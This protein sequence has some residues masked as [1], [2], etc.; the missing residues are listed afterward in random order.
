MAILYGT[1]SNGETLPV[2]VDQFGNLLAKGIEGQPGQPGQ[3]GTPGEPGGEGPPGPPGTPGEGV[4][5][6]YGPDGAY[7][8]IVNGAPA[9]TDDPGPGPGPTPEPNIS[10]TNL[11]D[12]YSLYDATNSL[13][14]PPDPEAWLKQQPTFNLEELKQFEG[15]SRKNCIN[16]LKNYGAD[17]FSL[18][19]SFSK[20]LTVGWAMEWIG[21]TGIGNPA[22]VVTP[23]TSYMSL[24]QQQLGGVETGSAAGQWY[25]CWVS[26]L[27]N[28]EIETVNITW[29]YESRYQDSLQWFLRYYALEDAG[30]YALR[31]QTQ[32]EKQIKAL[33]E[34]T[35][36][37]DLSRPTQD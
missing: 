26:W 1:Q 2:L 35:P 22:P 29:D 19:E 5:L 27:C 10:C 14:L 36:H 24:V 20:V 18:T 7:L 31:R 25:W 6:P 33:Y 3:P 15:A 28:R 37:I 16:N 8:Q 17:T 12:K 34:M 30:T 11:L 21:S 4:P 32:F 9:W 23:D 13:I